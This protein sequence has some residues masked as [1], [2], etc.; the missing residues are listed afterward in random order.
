MLR[1]MLMPDFLADAAFAALVALLTVIAALAAARVFMRLEEVWVLAFLMFSTEL[2]ASTTLL[3]RARVNPDFSNLVSLW[4]MPVFCTSL[5][6]T[7]WAAM[8]MSPWG[9]DT[10]LPVWV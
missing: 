6:S 10:L 1:L 3:V 5:M 2:A 7:S 9:V 4:L 8:L